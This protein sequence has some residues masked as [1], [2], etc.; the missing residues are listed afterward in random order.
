[1]H[2]A[3]E[4]RSSNAAAQPAQQAV[5]EKL[6]QIL[7]QPACSVTEAGESWLKLHR[8]ALVLKTFMLQA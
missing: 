3:I 1:M 6:L 7:A 4:A 2:M 8:L 5:T